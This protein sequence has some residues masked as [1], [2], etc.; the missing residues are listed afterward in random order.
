VEGRPLL[1]RQKNTPVAVGKAA[2]KAGGS[3]HTRGLIDVHKKNEGGLLQAQVSSCLQLLKG[4]EEFGFPGFL[5]C[6][7]QSE[8]PQQSGDPGRAMLGHRWG[9]F[10]VLQLPIEGVRLTGV[11]LLYAA[12]S[13]ASPS[14]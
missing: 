13:P 3:V 6:S 14:N 7:L 5:G 11:A 2:R 10:T 4:G 9:S 8:T 12:L 1:V